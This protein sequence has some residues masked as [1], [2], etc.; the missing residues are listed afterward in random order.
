[1]RVTVDRNEQTDNFHDRLNFDLGNM[2][3]QLKSHLEIR[4]T[5]YLCTFAIRISMYF[6][7][8]IE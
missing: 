2:N 6:P 7:Y 1:M 4:E 5:V 3:K 8:P